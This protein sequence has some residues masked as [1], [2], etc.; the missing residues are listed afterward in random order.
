[1]SVRLIIDEYLGLMREQDEL[2]VFLPILL[3]AM[4]HE[5][6]FKPTRGRQY[7]VDI[8]SR[9]PGP[10]GRPAL[11]I[12]VVKCGEVDRAVWS[13]GENSIRHSIQEIGDVYLHSHV[14]PED[15]DLPKIIHPL[16]NG[17][18]SQTIV[19]EASTY[20]SNWSKQHGVKTQLVNGSKLSAWT[21]KFLLDE[22]ALPAPHRSLFRKLLVTVEE[23]AVAYQHG[24]ALVRALLTEAAV[25]AKTKNL[26]QKKLLTSLRAILLVNTIVSHW[27]RSEGNLE[28][29]YKVGEFSVLAIWSH[30]C[31]HGL[32]ENEAA[33]RVFHQLLGHHLTMAEHYHAKLNRYYRTQSAFAS[34]YGD[35]TL[36]VDRVFEELGRLGLLSTLYY[37]MGPGLPSFMERTQTLGSTIENLIGTH[38]IS[39]SPCFD[40]QTVDITLAVMGLLAGGRR[41][42]AEKW[43]HSLVD[44]LGFAKRLEIFAPISSDSFEDLVDLRNGAL[45]PSDAYAIST[46]IPVLGLLCGI[47]KLETTYDLLVNHVA[48]L[49]QGVTYNAWSPDAEYEAVLQ[50]GF[51]LR[52]SGSSEA[53]LVMPAAPEQL[54]ALL[55][56]PTDLP[57]IDSFQFVKYDVLWM[58]LMASRHFQVQ[59]PHRLAA[60]IFAKVLT[61]N[62][63]TSAES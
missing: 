48:P 37:L 38:T 46:L 55:V 10:R 56:E 39:C 30:L 2:D 20:L 21:E 3:S 47:L 6:V 1:M 57:P 27:A 34:V 36:V 9:G 45:D 12:W 41:E 16:T 52:S 54:E 49:F 4:K 53:F 43:V 23:P 29:P 58:G 18:F 40:R 15:R 5:I 62:V 50:D 24:A 22:F 8:V 42:I 35:H 31:V 7:G 19:H 59:I 26:R 13:V 33:R 61:V 63:A 25:P 32:H 44:R 28:T 14:L 11:H 60:T 17:V 51:A